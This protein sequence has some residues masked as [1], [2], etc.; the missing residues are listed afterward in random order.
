VESELHLS[1]VTPD[2]TV[3]DRKVKAISCMDIHG[4]YGILPNHAR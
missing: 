1:V 4:S 3:L 2:R